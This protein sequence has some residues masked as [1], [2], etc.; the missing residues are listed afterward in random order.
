[1][2]F[3]LTNIVR[4][5]KEDLEIGRCYIPHSKL[6]KYGIKKSISNLDKTKKIQDVLQDILEDADKFFKKAD[7][8]AKNLD[9]KK[10]LHLN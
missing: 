1:M 10:L 8:I 4:D 2:A 6:K 9:K 5:F 3:Q 7:E